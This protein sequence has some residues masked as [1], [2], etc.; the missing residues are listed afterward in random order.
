MNAAANQYGQLSEINAQN[1]A[2]TTGFYGSMGGSLLTAAGECW[3]AAELYG[4]WEDRRTCAVRFW[5]RHFYSKTFVGWIFVNL[6]H[7]YGI[8]AASKV[9]KY[10]L[11]RSLVKPLF[12]WFLLQAGKV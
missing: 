1:K 7:R 2:E 4:G 3:V 6:Y 12:D 9:R 10:R 8:W 11:I 5:L